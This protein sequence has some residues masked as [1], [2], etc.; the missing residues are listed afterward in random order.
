MVPQWMDYNA[1]T[2][3]LAVGESYGGTYELNATWFMDAKSRKKFRTRI[4]GAGH[5]RFSRDGEWFYV[6][7]GGISVFNMR[8]LDRLERG[9]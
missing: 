4:D 7:G 1:A 2:R 9:M 5:L 6:L 3:R 8:D